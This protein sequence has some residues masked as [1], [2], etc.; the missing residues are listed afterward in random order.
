[1]EKTGEFFVRTQKAAGGGEEKEG[2]AAPAL[3]FK[4]CVSHREIGRVDRFDLTHSRLRRRKRMIKSRKTCDP[5]LELP[6]KS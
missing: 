5:D 6:L 4:G 2:N 1:M 3:F